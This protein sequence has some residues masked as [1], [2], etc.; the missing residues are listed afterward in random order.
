MVDIASLAIQIDTSD[1]ARAESDLAKLNGAGSKAEKSAKGV[2]GAFTGAAKAAGVYR[3]AAGR[4]REANGKFVSDARK[5]ELGLK[6]VGK[7][8]GRASE[9]L[10]RNS[11]A[12]R[13]LSGNLVGLGSAARSM[14]GALGVVFGIREAAQAV[15]QYDQLTNRLRLVTE[16][17][18]QLAYAQ[19]S[20]GA[21]AQA[22][23]QSLDTTAQVYQRIAQNAKA[24]GL[25][26][27]EVGSI[28]E[29]VAK[30]VALSGVSA[31][32]ASAALTQFGQ[33]LASG[34]L[35]GDEL[36][37]ILEQT[38]AL[39]QAVARGLGVSTAELRAMGA[40]GKLTSQAI[41][42]ALENQKQAV[43]EL[44][45]SLE[46]T[47]GQALQA[48]GNSLTMAIGKLDNATGA[49][50]MF[51]ESVLSLSRAL[52]GFSTGEFLDFFRDDKESLAGFNNEIS[53]TKASI[54]DLQAA[55]RR[56]DE[57]DPGD[58]V[59]FKFSL[60]DKEKFDRELA[61]LGE[62]ER[63]LIE[64]RE[65]L[66][67]AGSAAGKDTPKGDDA[68]ETAKVNAEYEKYLA[69]LR[70]S[71]A[72]QGSNTKEAETRYK[73]ESGALGELTAKQGEALIA[74]ARRLD[75]KK[76][77]GI[78]SGESAKAAKAE[79]AAF[80]DL[81]DSLYPAEAAQREYNDQIAR[82]DKFLDGDQLAKAIDRLNHSIDGA[83]ATGPADAIEEYR[84]QFEK[85]HDELNP[86]EVA[87]REYGEQQDLLN[88][89]IARGGES[90]DKARGDLAKL[91]DQYEENTRETTQWAQLTEDAFERVNEAGADMWYD[92]FQDGKMTLDD[93]SNVV[94]R[95]AAEMAN[96]LTF[97]P[98]LTSLGNV[99]M[100]TNNQGGIGQV[101][102][103]L[104]GGGSASGGGA[105]GIGGALQQANQVRSLYSM[106]GTASSLWPALSGGYAS[107]GFG[108]ALGAGAS[109]IGSMFGIGSGAA[110]SAAAGSTAAGYGG[111]QMATWVA[112]QNAAA[113]GGTAAAG[114]MGGAISGAAS[115]MASMWWLAPL[116]GMWQSAQLWDD[117]VRI[118]GKDTSRLNNGR[119]GAVGDAAWAPFTAGSYA[120]ELMDKSLSFVADPLNLFGDKMDKLV[121]VL[122]GSPVTQAITNFIGKGLFGG[123]WEVKNYGLALGAID[124]GMTGQAYRDEKKDGG[125]FSSDKKRTR[126]S[127][128][129]PETLAALQDTFDATK[130]GVAGIFEALSFS[131]EEGSLAG[132]Q[133]ARK[134]ISTKGKTE[135]EIKEAV[136]EW[137]EKAANAMS[138]ELNRVFETGLDLDL[139][140]MQAFVGNLLG[141]NDVLRY[142]D[143]GM[144]DASV[145]GG[146]LAESLSA[147]AGGLDA[148][149]TNSQTYYAAFFTDAEKVEDTIDSITR[150]FESADVELAASREAYRAMVED[151]DLTT[152]AGQEM[153]ATLMALSGQAA[154]YFSIVEQ[155]AAQAAQVAQALLG[156]NVNSAYGT[157]QRSIQTERDRLTRN[158]Q[159]Q[160]AAEQQAASARSSAYA[161][162]IST[163][164]SSVQALRGLDSALDRALKTLLGTSDTAVEMM[165]KQA[166]STLQAAL[167]MGRSGKS[168]A[169][170]SG[171][172]DALDAASRVDTDVYST[173][174]DFEREQGRTAN[175][176]A[177]LGAI[178][179]KQLTAEER[180]LA[181]LQASSSAVQSSIGG[182]SSALTA[183]Y[184]RAMKALDEELA[185]AQSQL[186]A[187]NGIDNSVLTVAAA[188]AQMSS[189]V[190]A[191]LNYQTGNTDTGA[192]VN[193]SMISQLYKSILGY[194][195]DSEGQ[196][197]WQDRLSGGDT[198]T[199]LISALKLQAGAAAYDPAADTQAII[200]RLK[201]Q[202]ATGVP[203]FAKGGFHA[204]G[205]RVVGEQGPELE[206][207]GPSRIYNASQTA[208]MLGGGGSTE[209][210]RALRGEVAG[211]RSAL[212][213]IAKYT[214]STA[215]GV[216]QMNEIGL[217]QE[218]AA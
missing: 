20:I 1:V 129:D 207:T 85:L 140:G 184:E 19:Q 189:A 71:L 24:L 78:A 131:V 94:K 12:T 161:D 36:N 21:I 91:K 130:S 103:S 54:R 63:R 74:E 4:L 79:A 30:T 116:I 52:D 139:E 215:Y 75:G 188:V 180:L 143:V 183:E 49:S 114:G 89:I 39:A 213:A 13:N 29:T 117:G 186:D 34:T 174:S 99:I 31:E 17:T 176:I 105:G 80:Q 106:Y 204:G 214:E 124:G 154:Q 133:L 65:R 95:W 44:A 83:D 84:K 196:S 81:Y 115:S 137:F 100:G 11:S 167:Q 173:L 16:N 134:K 47:G 168:L 70:Q 190:V 165:R 40:E 113:A 181:Q 153:F 193:S 45:S 48:F 200:E 178:N 73:I 8:A 107:G 182:L 76:A 212:G 147:A 43:D 152:Q 149:A 97:K 201:W 33:A 126:Y 217:P 141:V 15:E 163:A 6:G 38:P 171:L 205:W 177:E 46:V 162:M 32:A 23:Y 26:F 125:W 55:R 86:A 175:L 122:T 118:S 7:E 136:G 191:A 88:D 104:L 112:A 35:R 187:L 90:A 164:S 57:S 18:A 132:L 159:A 92:F 199:D 68:G 179:G 77:Y 185:A 195:A 150:T 69:N 121:A 111:A 209:E 5:A 218:E 58:T 56:L 87:A 41:I 123:D 9:A 142:L 110:A 145:A 98:L 203:A 59:L 208:A 25:T 202:A 194:D 96:S 135:E 148:L 119:R 37:S 2:E 53:V 166:V 128:L 170:F 42:G 158:Y 206:V 72:L 157:L 169:G 3:D 210:L 120:V 146:K 62:K 151:I 82:L 93:L 155:Q 197:H 22:S 216:R 160:L 127:A 66:A 10:E 61:E 156:A 64:L 14:A 67:S 192:G 144:Y 101:W 109:A 138:D 172:E 211:L 28:T 198:Y 50:N 27:A 51:A 108:G 102:G 60:Y